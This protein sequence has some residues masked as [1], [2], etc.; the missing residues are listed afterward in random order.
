MD[1]N[2]AELVMPPQL[3][4]LHDYTSLEVYLMHV[5]T[6]EI[7]DANLSAYSHLGYSCS[8]L[9]NMTLHDLQP[10]VTKNETDNMLYPLIVGESQEQVYY[11]NF[12]RKDGS[13]YP[14]ELRLQCSREQ[15]P[16]MLVCIARET[17]NNECS[18][19]ATPD[20][21]L[22]EKLGHVVDTNE[23]LHSDEI[24]QI[25]LELENKNRLRSGLVTSTSHELYEPLT[26]IKSFAEIL[27][28]DM[29][30][31]DPELKNHFLARINDETDRLSCL[32]DDL[33]D[34]RKT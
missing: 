20:L 11:T 33:L 29:G 3:S 22:P 10:S 30:E 5:D 7:I 8:D 17:S 15:N 2:Y 31:L 25:N 32:I 18:N 21:P 24:G 9:A 12:Q 28:E 14:V 26:S 13:S 1:R 16:V 34:L 27:S 23:N 19:D 4:R 6:L